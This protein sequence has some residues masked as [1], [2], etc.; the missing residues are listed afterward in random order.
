M[1]ISKEEEN[2]VLRDLKEQQRYKKQRIHMNDEYNCF[3]QELE[4]NNID[5]TIKE[6]GNIVYRL[7]PPI[8]SD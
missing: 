5:Y 8:I 1:F 3:I 2:T 7:K 4:D 6:N